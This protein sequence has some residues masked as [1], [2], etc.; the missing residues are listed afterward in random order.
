MYKVKKGE[1]IE[2]VTLGQGKLFYLLDGSIILK[3]Q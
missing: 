2:S 1:S 3:K